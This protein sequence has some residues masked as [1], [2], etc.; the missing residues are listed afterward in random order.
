MRV[1][2]ENIQNQIQPIQDS[3]IIPTELGGEP[4]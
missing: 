3:L 2:L 4:V 1:M